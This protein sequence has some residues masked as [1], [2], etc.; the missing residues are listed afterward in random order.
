MAKV[1]KCAK[2]CGRGCTKAEYER[3]RKA[4]H[5]LCAKLGTGWLPRVW[6]NLGWHYAA[7][8]HFV[9]IHEQHYAP[10][11]TASYTVFF[12]AEKQFVAQGN[13]PIAAMAHAA[14]MQKQVA[15]FKAVLS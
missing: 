7:E 11:K 6:E 8:K 3:A 14:L 5:K 1:L 12:N 4:A 15:K 9:S 10:D 2:W 13:D